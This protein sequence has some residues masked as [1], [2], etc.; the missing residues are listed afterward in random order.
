MDVHGVD[1]PLYLGGRECDRQAGGGAVHYQ[2]LCLRLLDRRDGDTRRR[3]SPVGLQ[4]RRAR[5]VCN[6]GRLPAGHRPVGQPDYASYCSAAWPVG[7]GRPRLLPLPHYGGPHECHLPKRQVGTGHLG[8]D[9]A[10]GDG[11]GLGYMA[12]RRR[13]RPCRSTGWRN[14]GASDP[15]P[16]ARV[17]Q[18][19]QGPRLRAGSRLFVRLFQRRRLASVGH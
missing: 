13:Q 16:P 10:L 7:T 17:L 9:R 12:G 5:L 14:D 2:H 19:T 1:G 3:I 8:G 6:L 15:T 11:R 4:P 18:S